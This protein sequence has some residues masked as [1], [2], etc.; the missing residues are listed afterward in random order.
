MVETELI[1]SAYVIV[2]GLIGTSTLTV[3]P[4]FMEKGAMEK[5][6]EDIRKKAP[7]TRTA[8]ENYLLDAKYPG[9]F[10]EYKYRFFFGLLS[11]LGLTFAY[12]SA[13]VGSIATL[14]TLQAIIAGVTTS[15][16]L[17]AVA[18][19]IRTVG[20]TETTKPAVK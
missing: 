3:F 9:F 16:F 17:T 11:G 15:G 7:D 5:Q 8:E 1:N 19:K 13:N 12:L 6:Q 4:Y 10:A 2:G 14:S 20:T 18:D